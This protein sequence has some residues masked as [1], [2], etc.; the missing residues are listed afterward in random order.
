MLQKLKEFFD[1]KGQGI[2]EYALIL[3]FVAIIALFMFSNG[4]LKTA[5]SNG[6]SGVSSELNQ[7]NASITGGVKAKTFEVPTV[8][9]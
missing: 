2:V 7:M 9:D 3:G 5:V 8:G 4:G 1:E 6:F